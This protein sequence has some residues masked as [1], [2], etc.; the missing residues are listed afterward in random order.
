VIPGIPRRKNLQPSERLTSPV[1]SGSTPTMWST[2][3][4][5]TARTINSLLFVWGST[6]LLR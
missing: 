1:T 2:S 5:V 6:W 3:T 4:T